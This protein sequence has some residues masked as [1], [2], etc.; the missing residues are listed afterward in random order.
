[1]SIA[2]LPLYPHTSKIFDHE[3]ARFYK[4]SRT[5]TFLIPNISTDANPNVVIDKS[6][7]QYE[8]EATQK[9]ELELLEKKLTTQLENIKVMGNKWSDDN[10]PGPN[11]FA[12]NKA[13]ELISACI[14]NNFRPH[15]LTQL[16]EEG[17]GFV[18]KNQN[19][20]MYVEIYNDEEL[21]ILIEDFTQK[22]TLKNFE[23]HS[24]LEILQE[25][26]LFLD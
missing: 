15:R 24:I 20:Y 4:E 8:R 21:G 10:I 16:S 13:T 25:L 1:M 9:Q 19:R 6:D 11:S 7:I 12:L 5:D 14:A 17:I 23:V 26:P 18:F 2:T 22:K 3:L